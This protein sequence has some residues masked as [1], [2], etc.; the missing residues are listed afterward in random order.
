MSDSIILRIFSKAGRSRV[1]IASSQSLFQ[2][3]QELSG[4]LSIPPKTIQLFTD[5]GLK[6]P[7]PGRDTQSLKAI[8]LKNG[9]IIHVGNQ[10]AELASV[11]QA[12]AAAAAK[13]AAA[14]AATAKAAEEEKAGS[15]MIDTSGKQPAEESKEDKGSTSAPATR[16]R[17]NHISTQKCVHCLTHEQSAGLV[18]D[19]KHES[20]DNYITS[21]RKK[22]AK[23]HA[24]N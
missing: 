3:K 15:S 8:G 20:F 24:S 6:K 5:Q 22:C 4:R 17:C 11:A 16:P 2:L 23:S 19:R 10:D 7:V 9:D 14:E 18:A 13:A 1:E 21:M 12:Q